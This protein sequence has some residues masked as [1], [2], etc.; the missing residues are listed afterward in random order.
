MI[1]PGTGSAER[2]C[3]EP[4]LDG[5]E[6]CEI[7][8]PGIHRNG[9]KGS[10]AVTRVA[11]R[12][13]SIDAQL[14]DISRLQPRIAIA[15]VHQRQLENAA[16]AARAGADH[17]ARFHARAARRIREHLA[18]APVDVR[19]R[20]ARVLDAVDARGH[21]EV[22]TLIAS[23]VLELI[24]RHE[25]GTKRRRKV[26]A[27]HRTHAELHL[28][29]LNIACTPVVHD[30]VSGD[31]LL[32]LVRIEVSAGHANHRRDLELV[33]EL[34]CNRVESRRHHQGRRWHRDC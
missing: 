15:A 29:T 25:H 24:R 19:E 1:A 10:P 14:D 5:V 34:R 27:L 11:K 22:V 30:A 9:R 12:A 6:T 26:L 16:G 33:V 23:P 31:R 7:S 2:S 4:R 3:R 17:V 18:E 32:R 28:S 20:C 13:Q 21:R 8:V